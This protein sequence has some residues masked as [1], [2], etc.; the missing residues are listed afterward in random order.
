MDNSSRCHHCRTLDK[1]NIHPGQFPELYEENEKVTDR[2]ISEAVIEDDDKFSE[3]ILHHISSLGENNDY[4]QDSELAV[5][6]AQLCLASR[7]EFDLGNDHSFICCRG[8]DSFDIKKKRA[9]ASILCQRCRGNL[10]N[11]KRYT[12]RKEVNKEERVKAQ[13]RTPIDSLGSE[14]KKQ[15][16]ENLRNNCKI[17]SRKLQRALDTIDAKEVELAVTHEMHGHMIKAAEQYVKKCK[18]MSTEKS[19]EKL[20]DDL[21]ANAPY[22]NNKKVS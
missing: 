2:S 14:E 22:E 9:N 19:I 15:R 20:I 5:A 21:V 1:G 12:Q 18:N 11:S 4:A 3:R 8:C 6:A 13:S 10:K 7:Y 17:E 16:Y